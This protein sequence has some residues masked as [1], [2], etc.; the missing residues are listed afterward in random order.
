MALAGKNSFIKP[1]VIRLSL[2]I[3]LP[4][5]LV[6][7]LQSPDH[8]DRHHSLIFLRWKAY[9]SCSTIATAVQT[10]LQLT[11]TSRV[12]FLRC[13]RNFL[14]GDSRAWG[15]EENTPFL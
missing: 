13:K 14:L 12:D 4:D 11:E 3:I 10:A 7:L 2:L 5:I 1:T 15:E 6:T 8:R 9:P